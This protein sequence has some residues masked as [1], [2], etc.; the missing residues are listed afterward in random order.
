MALCFSV[1]FAIAIGIIAKNHSQGS[2]NPASSDPNP[3]R[4]AATNE[5]AEQSKRRAAPEEKSLRDAREQVQ[6]RKLMEESKDRMMAVLV[7]P[8]QKTIQ[9]ASPNPGEIA[10]G[11]VTI[12]EKMRGAVMRLRALPAPPTGQVCDAWWMLKNAPPAKAA[13]FVSG[14]DQSLYLDPPPKGSILISFSI[15]MEPSRGAT[16]PSGQ[17]M[18]QG[19]FPE[20]ARQIASREK[21]SV[22][23]KF[24]G[25]GQKKLGYNAA[26]SPESWYLMVPPLDPV[27]N[28]LDRTAPPSRWSIISSFSNHGE[29][30]S[31]LIEPGGQPIYLAAVCMAA[32]DPRLKSN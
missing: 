31:A 11:T 4:I 1:G 9:L 29:C 10:N 7:A 17:V 26:P 8:D 15:T 6:Q 30:S 28:E 32:N 2:R 22:R 5:T 3:T 18:L 25:Q 12:S 24:A 14:I 23:P 19:K 16:A 20:P 13:E 27:S 21:N